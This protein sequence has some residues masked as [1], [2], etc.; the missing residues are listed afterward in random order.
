VATAVAVGI[1]VLG[2]AVSLFL[3]KGSPHER[4]LGPGAGPHVGLP[5]GKAGHAVHGRTAGERVVVPR[6]VGRSALRAWKRLT[7][8]GLRLK[9]VRPVNGRPGIVVRT[10]PAPMKSVPRDSAVVLFVG[11]AADRTATPT[12]SSAR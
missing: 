5:T 3:V 10:S 11:S 7:S 4:L 9:G 12:L 8:A 1:I 2:I 6:L